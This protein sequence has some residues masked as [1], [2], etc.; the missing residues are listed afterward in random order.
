MLRGGSWNNNVDNA[1]ALAR[2]RNWNTDR[3]N[4]IGF[5]VVV[6][7]SSSTFFRPFSGGTDLTGL[8]K[9]VRSV[10]RPAGPPAPARFRQC[11]LTSH[12]WSADRGEG[13]ERRRAGLVCTHYERSGGAARVR[14]I[15][16]LGA[17][18]RPAPTQNSANHAERVNDPRCATTSHQRSIS[19]HQPHEML[20]WSIAVAS[21]AWPTRSA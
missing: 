15:Q 20:R 11:R 12:K 5:R 13:E 6:A 1:S 9:P 17:R 4:N 3:N 7:V 21:I 14:R 18:R 2:N 10:P 8:R 16:K 19:G